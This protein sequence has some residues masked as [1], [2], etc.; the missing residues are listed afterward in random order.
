MAEGDDD[1]FLAKLGR[2]RAKHG[3]A[4]QGGQ[5]RWYPA[6]DWGVATQAGCLSFTAALPPLSC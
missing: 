6:C 5:C 3:P 4:A 2:I 1:R